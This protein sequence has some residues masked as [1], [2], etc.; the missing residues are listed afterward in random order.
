[1][2]PEEFISTIR[3]SSSEWSLSQ[4]RLLLDL[5][6]DRPVMLI[7]ASEPVER[8]LLVL[9]SPHRLPEDISGGEE[10]IFSH[11]QITGLLNEVNTAYIRGL[12]EEYRD[13]APDNTYG[14]VRASNLEFREQD[15]VVE[16]GL[17]FDLRDSLKSLLGICFQPAAQI[18]IGFEMDEE[19][20]KAEAQVDCLNKTRIQGPSFWT[21]P[22]LPVFDGQ[23]LN[24]GDS[25]FWRH[26]FERYPGTSGAICISR[27]GL[28]REGDSCFMAFSSF[29][30]TAFK[31]VYNAS[32]PTFSLAGTAEFEWKGY[33]SLS[34]LTPDPCL[35]F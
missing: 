20:L 12:L 16:A 2:Q 21:H 23:G 30:D 9:D 27:V 24:R 32:L 25:V 33:W 19:H 5:Q 29:T 34:G 35:V 31:N 26:F 4:V 6:A 7:R 1:M 28:S 22:D 10:L 17:L 15:G 11:N 18:L 8:F 14:L 13:L 3:L